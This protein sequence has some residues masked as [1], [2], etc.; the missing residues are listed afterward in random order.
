MLV[1]QGIS[2]FAFDLPEHDYA[3]DDYPIAWADVLHQIS[4]E[5]YAYRLG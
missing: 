4:G 1:V 3:V 2:G 5:D